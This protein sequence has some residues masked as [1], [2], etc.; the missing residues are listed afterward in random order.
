MCDEI[1]QCDFFAVARWHLDRFGQMFC[2]RIIQLHFA[3]FHHVHKQ[4]R[5]ER[6][7]HRADLENRVAIHFLIGAVVQL[8]GC[9]NS[10]A[11]LIHQTDHHAYIYVCAG[12]A[13]VQEPF[14][15]VDLGIGEIVLGLS[16]ESG[17]KQ[18]RDVAEGS[19]GF[20]NAHGF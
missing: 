16:W 12:E 1:K 6:L 20:G 9:E 5:G 7:R 4:Q 10:A 14:G 17:G 2:N 15:S 13:S 18:E 8:S 11:A 19:S 3:A